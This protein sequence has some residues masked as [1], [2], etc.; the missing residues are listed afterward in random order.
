[1][2]LILLFL[3]VCLA[4]AGSSL[5]HAGFS[6]VEA[7]RVGWWWGGAA[8]LLGCAGFV[9]VHGMRVFFCFLNRCLLHRQADSLPLS[10]QGSPKEV[11]FSIGYH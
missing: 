10:H 5:L 9:G 3:C 11:T 8:S 7:S 1:M 2:H 6:L 4:K